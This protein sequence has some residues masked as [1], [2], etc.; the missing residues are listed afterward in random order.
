MQKP[1]LINDNL[2]ASQEMPV[3]GLFAGR[4]CSNLKWELKYWTILPLLALLIA[5][6]MAI[7]I[8]LLRVPG[9]ED[10]FGGDSQSFFEKGLVVHVTFAFLIWYVGVQGS[11]MVIVSSNGRPLLLVETIIGRIAVGFAFLSF[12]FILIPALFNLGETS[13]N[14]YVP[15]LIQPLFLFGLILLGIGLLLVIGRLLIRVCLHYYSDPVVLAVTCSGVIVIISFICLFLAASDIPVGLI[16]SEIAEHI[17]WGMGH[18]IQF[19]HTLLFMVCFFIL[20]R[21]CMGETPISNLVLNVLAVLLLAGAAIGPLIYAS[22]DSSDPR[23]IT[24]FTGLYWYVLPLP[25]L[26]FLGGAL[27]FIRTVFGSLRNQMPEIIGISL[28]LILFGFGGVIGFF[29][30]GGDTRTPAHYH[31]ELIA[32]TLVFMCCYFALFLPLLTLQVPSKQARLYCYCFLGIGQLLHSSGLFSAGLVGVAR[33]VAAE[34][35]MLETSRQVASM[36]LMGVGGLV[37]VIGGIIFIVLA[38]RSFYIGRPQFSEGE[39]LTSNV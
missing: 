22:Y 9:I 34:E 15:I 12:L 10:V 24:A 35:Q 4:M 13:T 30:G 28:A 25:I 20:C 38:L 31:A 37:A 21:G 19:S 39:P 6:V 27:K 17:F 23:Q 3:D 2:D 16:K 29:G 8:A 5:G 32:V 7:L 33:K 1:V 11:L 14:N 26:I 36:A 18:I